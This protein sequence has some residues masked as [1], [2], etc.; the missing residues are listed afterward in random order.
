MRGF[1]RAL[2]TEVSLAMGHAAIANDGDIAIHGGI[3]CRLGI[4]GRWA[5][6]G[7][8][9]QGSS[10]NAQRR[11]T[12]L[13]QDVATEAEHRASTTRPIPPARPERAHTED[14]V[15]HPTGKQSPQGMRRPGS[16]LTSL[17]YSTLGR[18]TKLSTQRSRIL[19]YP[20]DGKSALLE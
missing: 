2:I 14:T 13:Q 8:S 12:D 6:G 5:A 10:P 20:F 3:V 11:E 1:P 4:E 9:V 18:T 16:D 17:K 15:A 19:R 7:L